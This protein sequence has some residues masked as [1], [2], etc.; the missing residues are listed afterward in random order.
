MLRSIVMP[1]ESLLCGCVARMR[2][3]TLYDKG[4]AL[5]DG[6]LDGLRL[7]RRRFETILS[8]II[9]WIIELTTSCVLW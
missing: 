8:D 9:E 5:G 3:P 1:G 2:G 6:S 4:V 7:V